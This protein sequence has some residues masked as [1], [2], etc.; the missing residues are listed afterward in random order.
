M[1]HLVNGITVAR[2]PINLAAWYPD[3]GAVALDRDFVLD[4]DTSTARIA[5]LLIHELTHARLDAAGFRQA[6]LAPER[7]ERICYL[8]ER[9]FI[10]RLP[11]SHS[12]QQLA[13]LN[14]RYF[15]AL[16]WYFSDA[17]V[18]R[19]MAEWRSK[20]PVWWRVAYDALR[21]ARR[22]VLGSQQSTICEEG[23][24]AFRERARQRRAAAL[25]AS[26]RRS[27]VETWIR[28][29]SA[30][31]LVGVGLHSDTLENMTQEP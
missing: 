16:P 26:R 11:Q 4:P 1:A 7:Y 21:A 17:S 31:A 5:S 3:L 28:R 8:A 6:T 15:D 2:L 13:E 14:Q 20:Q 23:C 9:N 25:A 30:S 27:M 12:P 10:A 24:A 29:V 19:R 18:A 22:G